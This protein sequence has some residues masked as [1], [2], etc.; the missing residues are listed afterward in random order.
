M[1]LSRR[2]IKT[3]VRADPGRTVD[4]YL[5]GAARRWHVHH[6]ASEGGAHRSRMASGNGGADLGRV[7]RR[8]DY[9]R[10]HRRHASVEPPP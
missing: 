6:E 5:L 1:R 3:S 10:A 2:S 9:I 4:G 7:A 8:P